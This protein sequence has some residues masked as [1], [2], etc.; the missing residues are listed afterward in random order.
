MIAVQTYSS[1]PLPRKLW[2]TESFQKPNSDEFKAELSEYG[3]FF[4]RTEENA[5][6]V[7][8]ESPDPGATIFYSQG[9]FDENS[10]C[11]DEFTEKPEKALD[12]YAWLM[13]NLKKNW[14]K[15]QG[16]NPVVS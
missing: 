15:W 3:I 1:K 8:L 2:F 9:F 16:G 14:R 4:W 5:R 11:I 7:S 12:S 6:G 13:W 10:Y